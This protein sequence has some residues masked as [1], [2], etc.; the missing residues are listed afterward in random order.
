MFLARFS[1]GMKTVVF[2]WLDPV[3]C[4]FALQ[5]LHSSLGF[6][7]SASLPQVSFRPGFGSALAAFLEP[8]QKY[9]G[10]PASLMVTRGQPSVAEVKQGH[11][12]STEATSTGD[13]IQPPRSLGQNQTVRYTTHQPIQSWESFHSRLSLGYPSHSQS[14]NVIFI[15]LGSSS[16]QSSFTA[17][18]FV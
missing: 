2:A 16:S 12:R 11:P 3:R 8:M 4:R 1:R 5:H 17:G 7:Q 14:S 18:P 10:Q 13:A 9:T 15:L 6:L